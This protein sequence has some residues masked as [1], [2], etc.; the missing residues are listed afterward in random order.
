MGSKKGLG[1]LV[2]QATTSL[3]DPEPHD[4]ATLAGPRYLTLA[5]KEAR[6]RDDQAD[7]LSTLT[8]QLNKKRGGAGERITDNT[9]IR[10]AVDLL[11]QQADTLG[12]TTE[13][14]LRK[15]VGL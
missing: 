15:S 1:S 7:Q 11:L 10:V 8:R 12:G 5:R 14:E 2:D 9:L 6:I 4:A 13:T 3:A